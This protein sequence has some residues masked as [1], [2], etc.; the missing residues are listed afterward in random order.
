MLLR[1]ERTH[2]LVERGSNVRLGDGDAHGIG[3]A[4]AQR[5]GAHLDARKVALGV[6]RG[7]KKTRVKKTNE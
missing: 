1:Y 7:P 4:L 5:T 2:G 6:T 3:D